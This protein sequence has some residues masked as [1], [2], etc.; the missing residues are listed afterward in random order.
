M[1]GQGHEREHQP[2][3]KGRKGRRKMS[4]M[5]M[6]QSRPIISSFPVT[7]P[8]LT[9]TVST[10]LRGGVFLNSSMPRTN[11]KHQKCESWYFPVKSLKRGVKED[12][13]DNAR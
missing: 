2:G 6:L 1:R 5:T 4:R 10:L 7:Q 12:M 3:M 11:P 13:V 9:I 8:G